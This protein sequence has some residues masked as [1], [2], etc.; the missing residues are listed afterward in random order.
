MFLEHE[1]S[2]DIKTLV[3]QHIKNTNIKKPS[4]TDYISMTHTELEQLSCCFIGDWLCFTSS[5][6]TWTQPLWQTVAAQQG[7]EA[8][9]KCPFQQLDSL[10]CLH[11]LVSKRQLFLISTLKQCFCQ[12][13]SA[14][15]SRNLSLSLVNPIA[16][17]LGW[18]S[19]LGVFLLTLT[20]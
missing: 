4:N 2:E 9:D 6:V 13:T 7:K 14:S 10:A 8:S 19:I 15:T 16:Y 18:H 3:V 20:C 12:R 17:L 5:I 1:V 11:S